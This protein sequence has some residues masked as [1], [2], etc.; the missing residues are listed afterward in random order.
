MAYFHRGGADKTDSRRLPP[1]EAPGIDE[2]GKEGI[3]GQFHEPVVTDLG[4]KKAAQV[5]AEITLVIPLEATVAA[6]AE[7]QDNSHYLTQGQAARRKPRILLGSGQTM[8]LAIGFKG[9]TKV[10]D[11][12]IDSGYSIFVHK[13]P[14]PFPV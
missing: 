14:L 6:E 11:I 5:E 2:Q 10:I 9:L 4:G 8:G 12:A 1:P 3:A 13:K 7:Q